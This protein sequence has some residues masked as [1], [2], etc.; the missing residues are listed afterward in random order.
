MERL[1]VILSN[2][3]TEYT[4]LHALSS[5]SIVQSTGRSFHYTLC[6]SDGW[7]SIMA[8]NIWNTGIIYWYDLYVVKLPFSGI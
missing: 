1:P 5:L 3:H 2:T 4:L 8:N 7:R 6:L